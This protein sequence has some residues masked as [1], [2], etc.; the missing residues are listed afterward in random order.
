M[1]SASYFGRLINTQL[2]QKD[3]E[4]ND[5]IWNAETDEQR[6]EAQQR[7]NEFSSERYDAYEYDEDGNPKF[8]E[9]GNMVVLSHG[10]E[11]KLDF[12]AYGYNYNTGKNF[13]KQELLGF[14]T[15][16][17]AFIKKWEI[18]LPEVSLQLDSA[19][20]SFSERCIPVG[21]LCPEA[22]K[23]S[24]NEGF[25]I[26]DKENYEKAKTVSDELYPEQEFYRREIV[27]KYV[28]PENAVYGA[29]FLP[30]DRNPA[31]TDTI[32]SSVGKFADDDS[33]ILLSNALSQGLTEV[34]YMVETLSQVFLWAG[35]V[36]AIFSALLLCNFISVSISYK[37]K[38]IGILR[39][40]GARSF[41]V[42]KI[43]FSESFVITAICVLLSIVGGGVV[44]AVLN[45][46]FA[47]LLSGASVFV[48]GPLSV[49]MLIGVA[50]LTAVLATFLPV[51]HAAR[52]KP[53]ESIRAL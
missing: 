8:D 12:L 23:Y 52:K 41:D 39:A 37:K 9:N 21:I 44:C 14:F 42:F 36:L 2:R 22:D 19:S 53:V 4:L 5:A 15:E 29:I 13:T 50:F 7:Y 51:Y 18:A 38:E 34:N 6:N 32:V 20:Y 35:L 25:I 43:F 28:E 24:S 46:E 10:I 11:S 27:T 40:V 16:T 49:L 48:F 45:K 47:V 17:A 26:L 30:Y 33:K 31:A 3:S 1:L